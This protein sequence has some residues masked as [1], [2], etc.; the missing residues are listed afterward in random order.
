MATNVMINE[1]T[2]GTVQAEMNAKEELNAMVNYIH[3]RKE[4]A[5]Q[6][7]EDEKN[8]VSKSKLSKRDWDE[9]QSYKYAIF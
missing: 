5:A 6:Q 9:M 7:T 1:S 8:G 2:K 4:K 3:Q